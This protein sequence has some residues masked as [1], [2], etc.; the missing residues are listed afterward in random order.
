[1]G[2]FEQDGGGFWDTGL[3]EMKGGR[4]VNERDGSCEIKIRGVE[5]NVYGLV[6]ELTAA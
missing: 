2:G 4:K 5:M 6:G 3:A 1:M